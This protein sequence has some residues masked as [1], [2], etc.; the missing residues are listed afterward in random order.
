MTQ[1]LIAPEN[2]EWWK[3]TYDNALK[4]YFFFKR[5]VKDDQIILVD[6]IFSNMS[7]FVLIQEQDP[8]KDK[9]FQFQH[10]LL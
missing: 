6:A 10:Y 3:N 7:K 2:I 5:L 8:W 4:R 9:W 1:Y